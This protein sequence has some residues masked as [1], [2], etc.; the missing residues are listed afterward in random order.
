MTLMGYADRLSARP[1]ERV[2]CMVSCDYEAYEVSVVRFRGSLW[3]KRPIAPEPVACDVAGMYP[4]RVQPVPNGSCV[5]IPL[6]PRPSLTEGFTVIGWISPTLPSPGAVQ[7]ILSWPGEGGAPGIL[8]AI[9]PTGA[10]TFESGGASAITTD[11]LISGRWYFVAAVWD[12][13]LELCELTCVMERRGWLSEALVRTEGRWS[14]LAPVPGETLLFGAGRLDGVLPGDCYNGK[15]D[16]PSLWSR[17]L[18]EAEIVRI[19]D[20]VDPLELGD[21][22]EGCWDFAQHLASDRAVDRSPYGRTGHCLNA[23]TRGLTGAKWTGREVDP[24]LAPGEYG[25]IAF[26][27]DDLGDCA[28]EPSFSFMVPAGWRPGVYGVRLEAGGVVEH[29]PLYVR[30]S[31]ASPPPP[32]LYLAPTNTYLAYGNER[33]FLGIEAAPDFIERTVQEPVTLTERDHF[34]IEH[35]E[36]GAS[37]YDLH[38]DKT[39]ICYSS[40][41]R[42][43][44]TMR[45]DTSSW[46]TGHPRHFSADLFLIEWLEAKGYDYDVA[47]DED[48]HREGVAALEP[49][50]VVLT[51]SHPEYWTS[52]AMDALET[53][54]ASGGRLMYLGGNGFYWVTGISDEQ[55]HIVEIRRGIS[56]TRAWNSHPG[57]IHLSSTGEL[58]GLWRNRNRFPN[59]LVGVGFAAQGWGGAP[60]YRRLPDSDH[61]DAAFIFDGVSDSEILGEYGLIMGGAAGDEVDR[62]DLHLGTPPETL[63]LATTEGLHSDYYQLV[64]EDCTFML[65]G[66]GGTEEPRVRADLTY[67][68]DP[69][70]GGAV[71]STGSINWIGSLMWNDGDNDVARIT[72]NV[73]NRFQER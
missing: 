66:R 72:A 2:H 48:L 25:A 24:R 64:I 19:R 71:F 61:P 10:V 32:I 52:P 69:A 70:T 15:L 29:I 8:L 60:G 65:A 57:E 54:L 34:L 36:L 63:R 44:V 6:R 18:S 41:L 7:G 1:G 55:P 30:G 53:Y 56:G 13:A 58:G 21:R 12:P 16:R 5:E 28:W 17:A 49:Y 35:P 9:D 47:T 20:R 50:G 40:R 27:D 59:R 4:G 14:S 62:F 39:G 11:P 68:H 73:L 45:P 46:T 42:P 22:L 37:V 38:R 43:V 51:G 31:S 67:L 33:L 3:P 26:H 23:P